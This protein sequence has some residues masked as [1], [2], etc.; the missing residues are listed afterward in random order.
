MLSLGHTGW[1]MV[2]EGSSESPMADDSGAC[3]SSPELVATVAEAGPVGSSALNPDQQSGSPE[4]WLFREPGPS[5]DPGALN[6][7]PK[8]PGL[9][10]VLAFHRPAR[11]ILG[12]LQNL[13]LLSQSHPG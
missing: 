3:C 13:S 11:L 10:W 7:C 4:L 1:A 5:W 8:P 6:V 2:W 9:A 12:E